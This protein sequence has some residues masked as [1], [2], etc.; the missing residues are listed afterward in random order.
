MAAEKQHLTQAG[1]DRL[2][3]ELA[4][5]NE[6]KLPDVIKKLTEASEQ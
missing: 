5:L 6:V 1:Y 2:I 3:K 4:E